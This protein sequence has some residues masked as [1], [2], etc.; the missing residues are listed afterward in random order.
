MLAFRSVVSVLLRALGEV[1]LHLKAGL[2]PGST[3]TVPGGGPHC[4]PK[5]DDSPHA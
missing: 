3:T 1:S 5:L 2:R 4:Q